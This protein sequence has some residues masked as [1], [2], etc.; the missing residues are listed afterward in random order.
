MTECFKPSELNEL[1]G[2]NAIKVP[3]SG[4][5]FKEV[6][7]NLV[8]ATENNPDIKM[9]VRCL[10]ANRFFNDKDDLDY[11]DYPTYLYD[12][13]LLNDV[14][15]LFNKSIL[16]VAVQDVIGYNRSGKIEMSFDDYCNWDDYYTFGKEVVDANYHRDTIERAEQMYPIT[17]EDY[18]KINAN[19]EQNVV[20]LARENPDIEYYIYISPYSIYYMDYWYQLGQLERQ[21]AAEKYVIELLLQQ[22]NIHVFSFFME[23]ELIENLDNYRDVAHHKGDVNSQIL[24]WMSEGKHELT[25]D[26]YEAYCQEEWDYYMNF[27]YDSLFE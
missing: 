13:N 1:F 17:E 3:F 11:N 23:H 19:I 12:D 16:L 26:N 4:G 8:V 9:I 15:Y 18:A 22:D 6:N 7:D 24:V 2:V 20:S 21:L 27:D 14:N 25:G 10:D 5:S